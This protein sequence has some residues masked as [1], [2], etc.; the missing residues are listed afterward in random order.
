MGN[1]ATAGNGGALVAP[2]L[3]SLVN[4]FYQN[5]ATGEGGA[6]FVEGGLSYNSIIESNTFLDNSALVGN[7]IKFGSYYGSLSATGN[8]F[9]SS[10]SSAEEISIR[11]AVTGTVEVLYNISTGGEIWDDPSV[12]K[13]SDASLPAWKSEGNRHSVRLSSLKFDAPGSRVKDNGGTT[14]TIAIARG[15]VA[16]NFVPASKALYLFGTDQRGLAR[17]SLFDAGSF[18]IQSASGGDSMGPTVLTVNP[19]KITL[20]GEIVTVFGA[21]LSG[22]TQIT[23]GGLNAEIIAA[24]PNSITFVTPKGLNGLQTLELTFASTK[25]TLEDALNFLVSAKSKTKTIV[26]GFAPNSVKLTRTMK[27]EIREFVRS[28]PDLTTVVCKGYT[29]APATIFDSALARKRGNV[30]CDYVKKKFPAIK[31]EVREGQHTNAPGSNVRRVRLI[32]L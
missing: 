13:P 20:S 30:V 14:K 32:M 17:D 11:S 3:V 4:T 26:S 1:Q 25:I 31:V 24:K 27:R 22:V 16:Q 8:I 23:V 9:A 6:I 15:S 18:E 29:S 10:T 21:V 19:K 12:W 28:N 2:Y 7:S 5:T